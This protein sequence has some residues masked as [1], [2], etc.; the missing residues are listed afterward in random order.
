MIQT[1]GKASN[2]RTYVLEATVQIQL[3]VLHNAGHGIHLYRSPKI[4]YGSPL[5]SK[6]DSSSFVSYFQAC[7]LHFQSVMQGVLCQEQ[8]VIHI[9]LPSVT[10]KSCRVTGPCV[11]SAHHSVHTPALPTEMVLSLNRL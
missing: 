3:T 10:I 8:P 1:C 9:V 6:Q 2:Q 5:S 4:R 7:L 11:T